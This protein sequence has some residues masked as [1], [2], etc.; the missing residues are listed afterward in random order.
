MPHKGALFKGEI[1]DLSLFDAKGWKRRDIT[2]YK[3]PLKSARIYSYPSAG[4]Y[5]TLVDSSSNLYKCKFSK[6]DKQ[7]HVCL[8]TPQKLKPWYHKEGYSDSHVN[9]IRD[10]GYRDKVYFEYTGDGLKFIIYT[11]K[12][13]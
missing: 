10:D 9:T 2:F 1:T 4:D 7:D 8:G 13:F 5:I 11:E 12:E 3:M 6:P